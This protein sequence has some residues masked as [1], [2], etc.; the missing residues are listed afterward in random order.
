MAEDGKQDF[1]LDIFKLLR[2]ELSVSIDSFDAEGAEPHASTFSGE[3]LTR[4]LK[5]QF[6]L[7]DQSLC[8]LGTE[9]AAQGRAA[10]TV[11]CTQNDLRAARLIPSN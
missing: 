3:D 1:R 8:E 5:E 10:I 7:D 2:D 9:L 6:G 11:R 4:I